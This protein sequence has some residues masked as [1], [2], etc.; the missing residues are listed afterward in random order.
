MEGY[1]ALGESVDALFMDPPRSGATE[2]FLAALI[3]L[4]PR[5]VVYISCN[6]ETQVRDLATL[7]KGGYTIEAIQPVDMVPHTAHVE[8]IVSLSR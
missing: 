2:E 1:A 8:N 6:P 4:A 7:D 5:R 3:K